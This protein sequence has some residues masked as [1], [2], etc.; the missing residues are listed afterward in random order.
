[1]A[2]KPAAAGVK[3]SKGAGGSKRSGASRVTDAQLRKDPAFMKHL[4]SAIRAERARVDIAAETPGPEVAAKTAKV[5]KDR[6]APATRSRAAPPRAASPRKARK[7][8]A[9]ALAAELSSLIPELDSE[10]L[11][12]LIEQARVHLYNMRVAE[13]EDAAVEAERASNRVHQAVPADEFQIH[14]AASGST[15]DLVWHDKWKMFT[16]EEMLAMVRIAS[17]KDAVAEVGGRLYRWLLAERRD[18]LAD[19]PFSGLADPKLK[20]LV[21]L[22]RK[23]FTV[24]G[25]K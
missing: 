10:G 25:E 15:Y 3:G 9:K 19:I 12:F 21:A 2:R 23:T 8:D 11:A 17:S 18:V 1:M 6:P 20:K 22:L 14:A 7:P 4:E 5:V 13:L 24:R 16:D